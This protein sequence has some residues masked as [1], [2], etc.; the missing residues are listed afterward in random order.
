MGKV[1]IMC[2]L[3]VVKCE[4]SCISIV[5]EERAGSNLINHNAP[6]YRP[7]LCRL[8]KWWSAPHILIDDI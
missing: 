7:S 2:R 4:L 6:F 3:A 1:L 5:E 8:R